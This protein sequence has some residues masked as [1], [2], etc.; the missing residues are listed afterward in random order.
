MF[1]LGGPTPG[2]IGSC[3]D[4][5]ELGDPEDFCT[6]QRALFCLRDREAERIDDEEYETCLGMVADDCNQFNFSDECFPPPTKLKQDAC[7]SALQSVDRLGTPN[8]E[9]EECSF[10]ALC[11]N[12]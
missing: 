5:P 2:S 3:A 6:D 12:E 10:D 1:L 11:G 7:L 9:I 4:A 8:D